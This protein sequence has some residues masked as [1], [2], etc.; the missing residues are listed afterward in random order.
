MNQTEL[1]QWL[2]LLQRLFQRG[3]WRQDIWPEWMQKS[4]AKKS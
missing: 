4:S 2:Q 3:D 1:R